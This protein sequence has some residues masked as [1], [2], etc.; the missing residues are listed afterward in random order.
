MPGALPF[1]GKYR[2]ID[3]ALSNIK[4][5][6]IT[7][8]AVF[9]YGNYRSLQ[10]HVGSG[11]RWDLDRR[12][13]GLFILPP[14]NMTY[15][16]E[17]MLTFQRMYEHIEYFRRSLQEYVLI[18]QAHII[19][20]IDFHIVLKNH[21]DSNADITEIMGEKVRLKSFILSKKLLLKYIIDYDSMP[22][23]TLND[24]VVNGPAVKINTYTHKG[25]T[26][27]IT[28]TFNYMK[29]NLDMLRFDIGRTIFSEDRP[30]LSKEK[31]APPARYEH[32]AKVFNSM[33][34][35]G[36]FINGSVKN[37]VIGRDVIIRNGAV[38]ENSIIMSNTIVEKNTFV[39]YAILDKGT[40]IKEGAFIE[41]T[42]Q[43]PYVSQKEQIITAQT[44]IHV[45]QVA[46]EAYPFIK[47]GGLA[48]VIGGL[49]RNLAKKGIQVSIILPLYKKIKEN[50]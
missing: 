42:I 11:K 47:T 16:T 6:H 3:F 48:D 45:L 50:Y 15:A 34:A 1:A 23:K 30:I 12:K 46:S 14:K 26:R 29:S 20:N 32:Q 8:V 37:S 36:C 43:E 10:D 39:S 44:D 18:I 38:I 2:L 17:D 33:I 21:I 25:Y 35:S 22:Y 19:W 7:N 9:P 40:I 49:S 4:H 5:A 31:T 13:D 41:G 24:L 27:Y 28:D